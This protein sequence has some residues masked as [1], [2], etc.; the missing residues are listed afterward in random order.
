VA[1]QCGSR[2]VMFRDVMP[3]KEERDKRMRPVDAAVS[4]SGCRRGSGSYYGRLSAALLR[5]LLCFG[6]GAG[7][8]QKAISVAFG[9]VDVLAGS[10]GAIRC[11]HGTTYALDGRRLHR[12]EGANGRVELVEM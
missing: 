11:G 4:G 7:R 8:D 10:Q 1:A 2:N 5:R 9:R 6:R 3:T 12:G